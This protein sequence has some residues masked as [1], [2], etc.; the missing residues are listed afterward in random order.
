MSD[1]HVENKFIKGPRA[2]GVV[3]AG[4]N[5]G[6]PRP[7]VE[8]G[9]TELVKYGLLDQ[10]KTLGWDVTFDEKFPVYELKGPEETGS[11]GKLKNVAYVSRVT[12]DLANTV[13]AF[14]EKKLI[15]LT[16][17]G[18]HSLA[19]GTIAGTS[20]VYSNLGVIW[21]DAHAD[22]NT[23]E[24]TDSGNLHGCPVSFLMGLAG[25]VPGFEWLQPCLA[26]NRLVYIGLRS[27]DDGEKKILRDHK[28]K[29][30]SMHDVDGH[31]IGR[32]ME[33]AL[34]YLGTNAPIHLSYDVDGIDPT[35]IAATGTPVRG[36]LTFREGHYICEKLYETGQ[37]VAMDLMEVNPS[38]GE[39]ITEKEQTIQV[40]CSLVR[41]AFGETLL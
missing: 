35:V 39:V 19:M 22:I 30:F 34:D 10:L 40:G 25:K 18:D 12:E 21:V 28:I 6:Q 20:R 1:S 17:G 24:S 38:L 15:P 7:G 32:V 5:G 16:L 11:S 29:A 9:P 41:A 27:V 8:Q 4:F 2:V 36:G 14:A 26:T 33:M 3:G 31:G 23:P 13:A 37:L